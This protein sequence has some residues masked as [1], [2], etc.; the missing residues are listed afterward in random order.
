[1]KFVREP[2]VH[3]FLLGAAMFVIYSLVSEDRG[4]M[5][6]HIIVTQGKIENLAAT[7]TRIWQHPPTDQELQ[8]LIQDY[9][10]EEVLYG[11]A[12]ALGLDRDDTVI[13][14]RLR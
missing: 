8:G 10:R 5:T 9:I 3:F 12:L 13:R 4:G 1:M 14:R 2:L 7:F 11:E 6:G